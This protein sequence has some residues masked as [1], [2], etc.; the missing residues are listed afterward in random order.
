[1]RRSAILL[2][3]AGF[4]LITAAWWFLLIAPKNRAITDA[5]DRLAVAMDEEIV[6]VQ[7]IQRLESIKSNELQYL[8]AINEVETNIPNEPQLDVFIEDITFLAEQAGVELSGIS[9]AVPVESGTTPGLFEMTVSLSVDGEYFEILGF[10]FGLEDL[11]RLVKVQSLSL[12]P[13]FETVVIE[14]DPGDDTD[15]PTEEPTTEE[16]ERIRL[17]TLST[18]I[19]AVAYTRS[20]VTVVT[21][22]PAEGE[23]PPPEEGAT[24]EGGGG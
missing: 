14:A 19:F 5:N 10:L 9:T 17:E 11:E 13:Q 6:L 21:T 4:L 22:P 2:I 15:D 24:E 20:G 16:V 7:S 23:A 1:M 3:V 18:E 12:V 8:A